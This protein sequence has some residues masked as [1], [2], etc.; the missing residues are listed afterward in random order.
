MAFP[1]TARSIAHDVT[2]RALARVGAVALAGL[3]SLPACAET[4]LT[5]AQAQRL[6]VAYSRQLPAQDMAIIAARDMAVAASRLPDPSLKF[7]L[8]N[9]PVNGSERYSVTEDFMTMRRVGIEQ[10]WT[11]ADKRHLR[12]ERYQREADKFQ[13]QK[14]MVIATIERDT[15]LAWFDRYYAE[16]MVAAIAEQA[17]QAKLEIE[18]AEGAYRGGRGSQADTLAARSALAAIEDR[19]SEATRR[20]RNAKIMLARWTGTSIDA[21]LAGKPLVEIIRLD[22]ATL[23]SALLHHPEIAV[24][25]KQ[26]DIAETDARL[27]QANKRSDWS[28]EVSFQQR[29]PAYSNMISIGVSLP[30]QWDQKNRQDREL[31]SKLAMVEQSKAERDE[32]LRE[33]VAKTRAMIDEWQN[34]RERS[35]RYEHELI[36]LAKQRVDAALAAYRGGKTSL[37]DVLAAR[38]NEIDTRVQALQLQS[39]TARV[40]AQLNFLFPVVADMPMDMSTNKDSQ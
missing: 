14:T 18:A 28:V 12:A 35:A 38:R 17:A 39:D 13:V 6:A 4:P 21:P 15:A 11:R 26:I 32:M 10:E 31:S 25:N 24:L 36:P 2:I 40:W 22:P 8:D 34:G 9:L 20:V 23:D 37:A 27:A 3:L 29:G 1:L 19:A 5:L 30:L 33:H 16:Q 7:G